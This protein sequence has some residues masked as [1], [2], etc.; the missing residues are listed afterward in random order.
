MFEWRNGALFWFGHKWLGRLG[1]GGIT[2]FLLVLIASDRGNDPDT[3]THEAVHVEQQ[4]RLWF[5]GFWAA[6][7]WHHLR[8]LFVY[9]NWLLAYWNN[10][11]EIEARDVATLAREYRM[12]QAVK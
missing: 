7:A 5:V 4:R 6:Y 11:F 12:S 1:Y 2:L 8:G 3:E 10:P 9:R